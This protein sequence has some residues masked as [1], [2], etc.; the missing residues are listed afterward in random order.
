MNSIITCFEVAEKYMF[1][2]GKIENWIIFVET[3]KIDL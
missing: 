1:H 2:P 3:N